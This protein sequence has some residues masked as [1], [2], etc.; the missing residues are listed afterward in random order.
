MNRQTGLQFLNTVCS[1]KQKG[2][3]LLEILI[4]TVLIFMLFALIYAT[5][6]SLSRV[7]TELQDKMRSSEIVFKFLNSFN[8]EIKS[9][10]CEDGDED[11]SFGQKEISFITR[12][13]LSLYPVKVTYTVETAA[14][15]TET[16]YRRQGNLVNDYVFV[17]PVFENAESI[18]FLFYDGEVWGQTEEIEKITAVALE[19]NYAGEKFSFPVRLYMDKVDEEKK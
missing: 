14:D 19:M 4:T 1:G 8:K 11:F 7:T 18:E 15:N 10:I 16:L 13:R 6:F 5:F 17:S 9:V 3:T 2:F 12:D